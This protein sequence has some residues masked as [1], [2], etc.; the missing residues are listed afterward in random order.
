MFVHTVYFWLNEDSPADAS[1]NLIADCKD[2]LK[3]V[4][5]V[6]KLWAGPPANTPR[7]VVDNSY[8]CGLTVLFDNVAGHDV[9]Q[10]HPL[11]LEFIERNRA[12]WKRVQVY[13]YLTEA[14]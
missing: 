1:E 2:I 11:H 7:D 13:D 14:E 8:A 6:R 3:R 12:H 9:Y 10:D 5:T 4:S